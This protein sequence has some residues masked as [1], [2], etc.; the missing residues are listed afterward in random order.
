M[1]LADYLNSLALVRKM[2]DAKL[3]PAHGPVTDSVHARV[4]ATGDHQSH[5]RQPQHRG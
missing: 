2:P 3:F 5:R 1:P 4:G